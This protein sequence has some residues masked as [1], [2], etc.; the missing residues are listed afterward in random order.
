MIIRNCRF[1]FVVWAILLISTIIC[2]DKRIDFN[3]LYNNIFFIILWLN[4]KPTIYF[5]SEKNISQIL[6]SQLVRTSSSRS[7][8]SFYQILEAVNATTIE[9]T[10]KPTPI[11]YCPA[12]KIY[13]YS[14]DGEFTCTDCPAGSL[15]WFHH[16][17]FSIH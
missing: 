1:T 5:Y 7:I 11:P 12:G 13:N 4:I 2:A 16:N 9:P 10:A 14:S 6:L 8:T 17:K 3:G 15:L